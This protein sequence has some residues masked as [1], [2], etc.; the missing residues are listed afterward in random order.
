M[1]VI[2]CR[3]ADRCNVGAPNDTD[4]GVFLQWSHAVDHHFKGDFFMRSAATH[5]YVKAISLTATLDSLGVVAAL[6]GK[7][8]GRSPGLEVENCVASAIGSRPGDAN[9]S[10]LGGRGGG[11]VDST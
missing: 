6:G 5:L 10:R 11:D 9:A 7:S 3:D 2:L 8:A 1:K 4:D